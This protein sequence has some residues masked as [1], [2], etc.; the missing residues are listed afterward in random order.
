MDNARVMNLLKGDRKT[1]A[2]LISEVE[3]STEK[4]RDV[5][6][7]ILPHTGNAYV[8]G[9]T[10]P[11]GCGKSTLIEKLAIK[12]SQK[13][14]KRIGIISIEPSSPLSGGAFMGNRIRMRKAS[15]NRSIF[16]RSMAS[17]GSLGGLSRATSDAIKI[18]DAA[19]MDY[20]ILETVGAGQVQ[21]DIAKTAYTVVVVLQPEIGDFVQVMKAGFMEIEDIF[22][23]NKS[24]LEGADRAANDLSGMLS[25]IQRSDERWSPRI[26]RTVATTGKGISDLV[27]SIEEHRNYLISSGRM[28]QKQKEIAINEI[29]KI[30]DAELKERLAE[31]LA[32]IK[33][34]DTIEDVIAR[35]VS[36]YDVVRDLMVKGRKE[37]E[38]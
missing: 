5:I 6:N 31:K 33:V 22:V 36:A 37:E 32:N 8:I 16:I 7:S 13:D 29:E 27:R 3:A 24:D 34:Q 35:K 20:I 30:I 17:R 4:A 28:S 11:P 25:M 14:S 21:T 10:G 9:I 15:E 26:V 19:G 38:N 18:L 1:I 2:Q 23:I 12:M